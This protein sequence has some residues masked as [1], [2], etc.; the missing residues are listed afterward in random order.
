V[1]INN[2]T[3]ESD[4]IVK[5]IDFEHPENNHFLAINQFRID[6]PGCVKQ[7]I[8][9]DIVLFIN[10]I[11]LIVVECKKGGPTCSNPMAEAYIQLQRYMNNRKA[12]ALQG[13]KRGATFISA[14]IYLRSEQQALKRIT[15][16][17]LRGR[18]F[19]SLE[20]TMAAGRQCCQRYEHTATAN[21]WHVK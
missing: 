16:R 1:D 8:I 19:L 12:T 9:P 21:Q 5:L 15:A 11:P 3:G 2:A 7:F 6:T 13:L 4:P 18:A 10:G 20:D 17:L 14:V